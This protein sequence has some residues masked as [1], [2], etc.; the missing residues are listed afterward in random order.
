MQQTFLKHIEKNT[1]N[2]LLNRIN[3]T[4]FLLSVNELIMSIPSFYM[5]V[6]KD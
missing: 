3:Q 2:Y 6:F 4:K 5:G 1:L